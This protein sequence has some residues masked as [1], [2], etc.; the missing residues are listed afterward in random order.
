MMNP[1][2]PE[3]API[4]LRAKARKIPGRTV[5]G[6]GL[7]AVLPSR[8]VTTEPVESVTLVPMGTTRLRISAFPVVAALEAA[9]SGQ[10]RRGKV[11]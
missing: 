8:V 5:D 2:T 7:C 9:P 6:Y 1:F 3:A 4:T 11:I 10:R